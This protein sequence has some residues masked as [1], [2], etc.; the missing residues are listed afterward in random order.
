MLSDVS[1][2]AEWEV[3]EHPNG[4]IDG[5]YLRL[6]D[7]SET[8]RDFF[9]GSQTFYVF[10][11]LDPRK[12]YRVELTAHNFDQKLKRLDSEAITT[13]FS[14]GRPTLLRYALRGDAILMSS[15]SKGGVGSLIRDMLL[16]PAPA[17]SIWFVLGIVAAVILVSATLL[18]IFAWI[19]RDRRQQYGPIEDAPSTN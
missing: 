4:R 8:V 9:D 6:I 10:K 5:Y 3:P 18:G 1:A 17:A 12:S 16:V 2:K 11:N 7:S 15:G 13:T 19:R 14:T